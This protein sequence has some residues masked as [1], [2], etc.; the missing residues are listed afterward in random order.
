[1]SRNSDT[2]FSRTKQALKKEIKASKELM[3]KWL[4]EDVEICGPVVDLSYSEEQLISNIN[5]AKEEGK[6]TGRRV[7]RRGA[8]EQSSQRR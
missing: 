1:M 8:K 5:A 3:K 4:G 2:L 7:S 6:K